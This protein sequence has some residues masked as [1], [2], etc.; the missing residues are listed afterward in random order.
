MSAFPFLFR[1]IPQ[2]AQALLI[3]ALAASSILFACQA[4]AQVPAPPA[5]TDARSADDTGDK[6]GNSRGREEQLDEVKVEGE[7]DRKN[8]ILDL[9]DDPKPITA[10]SEE[11]LKTFDLVG[12]QDV[13]R[14]LGDVR[15]NDGNPRTGSFSLRGLTA[16]PGNDN[17][18]PSI[19]L[20]VDGVPYA[21]LALADG[22]DVVDVEQVN[23]TRGPQGTLGAKETSVGQINILTRQPGFTPEASGS[24]TLG[25]QNA[26]RA[27]F[28]AGG[29]IIDNILAWRIT[30]TRDQQ[31]GAWANQ[32]IDLKGLQTFPNIDRTY[33]RAQLLFTPTDKISLNLL[34]DHS[35]NG[36]ENINGLSFGKPTPDFYPDGTAVN[37]ANDANVKLLRRWFSQEPDYSAADYYKYNVDLDTTRPITTG[38]KGGLADFNWNYA[39]NHSVQYLWSVR[40]HYFF[41]SND[42]GTPFDISRDGGFITT[43]W[44]S[45]NQLRFTGKFDDLVDYTGG[46]SYL[47]TKTNSFSRTR[48][49]SDAG[50]W[51]ASAN[52]DSVTQL[53]TGGQY[54]D[55]DA[56][57]A[58]RE[59]MTDSLDRLYTGT[60]SYLRNREKAAFAQFD[61]HLSEPLTL[62]TGA[63]V[64]QASREL[65]QGNL[66]VDEGYGAALDPVTS[67]YGLALGGFAS[68]ATTGSIAGQTNSTA[69]LRLADSV[70]LKYFGVASTSTPGGAYNSLSAT[71]QKQVADAKAIRLASGGLSTRYGL[72]VAEPWKGDVYTGQASL[73]DKFND[74]VTGYGTVQFGQ[75][76]GISQFSGQLPNG[77]SGYPGPRSLPAGKESTTTFEVGVHTNWLDKALALNANVFR[78]N[79]KD[80]QQTVYFL[81]ELATSLQAP[82][83]PPI[84]T[85]GVGN[86]PKVRSQGLELDLAYT[87][88][89]DF[90]FRLAGACTDA[91]YLDYPTAGLPVELNHAPTNNPPY[92]DL[93][94][95]VL[96]DAPKVQFNSTLD[97]HHPVLDNKDLH[98]S[99]SYTYSGR[100]NTDA[101]LSSYA[102][103]DAYGL[104]DLSLG[105][106]RRDGTFDVNVVV[107]NL[108]NEDRGDVGFSSYTVYQHPRWVGVVFS[109]R[110]SGS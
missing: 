17:I 100:E 83:L 96:P 107:R 88:A 4:N 5:A 6:D 86:V 57:G 2:R 76:P 25:R 29:P 3:P 106:G 89:R 74:N 7:A 51:Y 16:G 22:S 8:A 87:F 75:K 43:Y 11:D 30:A 38:G 63:R 77:A 105:L 24:L 1:I 69:Q 45:F 82:N 64:T 46:L 23:V 55:L 97:Y 80:F 13:L 52:I 60:Q 67:N 93:S 98:A 73:S 99:L 12:I 39:D 84:Y 48:Y 53:P 15:W 54:V 10:V 102:W 66:L 21:Y 37:H 65:T 94:G 62:T 35:P 95:Y 18:D 44:Q 28:Q 27:Q 104:V 19:G 20:T 33:G 58:G 79:V 41:A 50:A 61:W 40:D 34:Y 81:D 14:R 36:G 70:A 78:A 68:N 42:D 103:T 9:Q 56:N 71:Q 108:L 101:A 26:L 91:K 49:G 92:R 31:D 72:Q 85:S 32:Y 110:F 90:S 59:L 47:L 109:G